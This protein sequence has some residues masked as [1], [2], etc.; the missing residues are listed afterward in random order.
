MKAYLRSSPALCL[1]SSRTLHNG[2]LTSWPI[3]SR[4]QGG[5]ISNLPIQDDKHPMIM[6]MQP[7]LQL[8]M[9]LLC[10]HNV[11]AI[12][13]C[14]LAMSWKSS[15]L[16]L[17]AKQYSALSPTSGLGAS[18]AHGYAAERSCPHLKMAVLM[19]LGQRR[20]CEHHEGLSCSS[21]SDATIWYLCW[22][23]PLWMSFVVLIFSYSGWY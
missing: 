5:L 23:M 11:I 4:G 2:Q 15:C 10:H 7:R 21:S 13:H 8:N 14:L 16:V 17:Y 12:I 19:L 3:K 18:R 22:T 6:S 20:S 1:L 9:R